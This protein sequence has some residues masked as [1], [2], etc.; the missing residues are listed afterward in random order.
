MEKAISSLMK[1]SSFGFSD[2]TTLANYE[3][4]ELYRKFATALMESEVPTKLDGDV[5]EQYMILL[6]EQA[7]PFEEKAIAEYESNMALVG[8]GVW[9]AG[10][11]KSLIALAALAPAKYGKQP[12]L[13]KVYDSLY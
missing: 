5:L 8:E 9:T 2:I 12:H 1:S 3:L 6:E 10:V 4:G 7:Y 11:R 13:E